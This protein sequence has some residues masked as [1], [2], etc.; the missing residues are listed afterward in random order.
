MLSTWDHNDYRQNEYI[1]N[2][3]GFCHIITKEHYYHIG[4]R[5]ANRKPMVEALL[6][7]YTPR[8]YINK[9]IAVNEQLAL[10]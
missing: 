8:R 6:T 3:W 7:N 4:A 5:E 1:K 2:V 10:W 9:H